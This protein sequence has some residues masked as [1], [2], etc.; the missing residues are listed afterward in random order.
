MNQPK[1]GS[2]TPVSSHRRA[3]PI[4]GGG[5][6]RGGGPK[7][8]NPIAGVVLGALGLLV[9][10]AVANLLWP[11]RTDIRVF[12]AD[13]MAR[14][15]TDMWRS[16][17]DRKPVALYFQ[18][19][20]VLR[21]EFHMTL[22]RS[23]VTGFRAARAAFVFKRGHKRS[24]YER[25][26]PDLQAYFADIRRISKTPFDVSLAART[27]LEWW[28]VHRERATHA[29][30]DLARSLAAAAA[31]L[32]HVDATSLGRYGKERALAMTIRDDRQAAGGVSEADW[33][34][35]DDHLRVSWR[36]LRVAVAR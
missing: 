7:R 35:I 16:Y 18:L 21:D 33:T 22:M 2:V 30:G 25:A 8:A 20:A 10:A 29:R 4:A 28:I 1:V 9:L 5:R 3:G 27:E 13:H 32:Y 11:V 15:D 23:L 34:A 14:L 6:W 31:A 19:A 12:D 26:L 24:D 17:Y 36:A